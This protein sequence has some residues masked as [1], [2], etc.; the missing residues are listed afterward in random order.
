MRITKLSL[1]LF[2]SY[3]HGEIQ[4]VDGTN[5]VYGENAQG[6]TNLLEAIFVFCTGRSHRSSVNKEIIYNNG[7]YSRIY[8]DFSDS[9]RDYHGSMK[10]YDGKKKMVTINDMPIK[11]ISEISEYINVV[12]FA[13]EDLS[14]IKDEP[15]VRRRFAD[16]AIGQLR[17]MYISLLTDYNKVLIQRNN[18]LKSIKKNRSAHD[19]IDIWNERLASLGSDITVYRNEFFNEIRPIAASIH[20]E[21]TGETL[22]VQ[23]ISSICGV[24]STNSG[25][26]RIRDLLLKKLEDSIYRDIELGTTGSGTHRDDFECVIDGRNAR[27]YGSQ[28]QQRSVV[29]SLKLAQTELIKLSRGAYPIIL[30]DDIMSELDESR[31]MYLAG[32]ILGKQVILTCTDRQSVH[33]EGN[34]AHFKVNNSKVERT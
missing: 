34:V 28:G 6:K 19:T 4:F 20:R 31:R 21:I 16:M 1:E 8:V 27:R 11:R 17:P 33:V 7:D 25:K 14:I 3:E 26:D 18:L 13:P 22:D 2:R 5:I 30:L 32:K 9:V 12:M 15:S 23:Y 24:G 29:L 10:I